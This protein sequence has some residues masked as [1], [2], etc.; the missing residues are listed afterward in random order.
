TDTTGQPVN[1]KL[2]KPALTVGRASDNDL[3]IPEAIPN[4][5]TVSKHHARLR[6]DQDDYIVRDLGSK[7]GLMVNGRHTVENLLRDGDHLSFGMVEAT[8]HQ[9]LASGSSAYTGGPRSGGTA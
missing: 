4:A 3:V 6:R 2:D 9:P 5:A 1:F 7:N 8:F